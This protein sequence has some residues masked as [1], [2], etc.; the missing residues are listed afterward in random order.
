M[1]SSLSSGESVRRNFIANVSHELKTP[2]TTIAGFIDGILDGTIPA[3]K[4]SYYLNIV[5]QEIKRLSRLVRTMLDLSRIDSGE[6]RLRP[7]RFDLT[8]TILI[9]L[10]SFEKAIDDKNLKSAGLNPQK[11]C[12]SMATPI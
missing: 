3:E 12:L 7:A 10:L 4:Q 9:A 6:L 2:M 8:N 5:S 1:A 11:V